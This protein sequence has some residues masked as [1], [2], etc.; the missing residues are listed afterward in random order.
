MSKKY[1]KLAEVI[2]LTEMDEDQIVS[3]ET[4]GLLSPLIEE[5][6]MLYCDEE[7]E[8]IRMIK[9]LTEELGVNLAGVEVILNMREQMLT[10][11]HEFEKIIDEMKMGILKELSEYESRIRRPRIEGKSSKA[12]KVKIDEE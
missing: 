7:L 3:F 11:Q 12:V 9:R 2:I 5:G 1:Y 10:M 6:Q 8:K 4:E